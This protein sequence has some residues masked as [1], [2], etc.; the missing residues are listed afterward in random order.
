MA[1]RPGAKRV[2]D[3]LADWHRQGVP[4][5]L[6]TRLVARYY[7]HLEGV[8]DVDRTPLWAGG[9]PGLV[10]WVL[11][12]AGRRLRTA[13]RA[14]VHRLMNE[15]ATDWAC[16]QARGEVP[17]W[18]FPCLDLALD[19]PEEA[20]ARL[21]SWPGGPA[22]FAAAG[23][24]DEATLFRLMAC[25]HP[26]RPVAVDPG[27]GAADVLGLARGIVADHAYDRLPLLADA[28]MDAGCDDEQVIGH[29]RSDGPHVRGC[30]VVD[31]VLGKGQ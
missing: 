12:A 14:Q 1:D 19:R 6:Y 23:P 10:R 5:G 24:I 16:R 2:L 8:Q 20:A 25:L 31:M 7:A 3:R 26:P 9:T 22:A 13:E 27:W 4:P 30:W 29:C 18:E 17:R 11:E 21:V 28:L 15:G